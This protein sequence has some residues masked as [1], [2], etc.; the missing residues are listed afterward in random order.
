[1]MMMLDAAGYPPLQD[2][3]RTADEDN[4]KGYYELERVKKLPEGDTAWL[5]D[6]GGKTVKVITALLEHLPKNYN[7]DVIVMR[8][9]MGEILASQKKMLERRG[10]EPDKISDVE[11]ATLFEK[12]FR[13]VMIWVEAQNN[14]RVVEV[15]YNELLTDPEDACKKVAAFLGNDLDIDAMIAKIDP[16]LYRQRAA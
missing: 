5:K 15:S 12:H 11:M 6:A 4:P 14:F 2:H 16:K 8:R 13:K 1:M 3:V 9:E 10:E 7:Y